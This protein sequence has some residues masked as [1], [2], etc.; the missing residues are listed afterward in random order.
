MTS[1]ELKSLVSGSFTLNQNEYLKYQFPDPV[2][3]SD[4]TLMQKPV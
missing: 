1:K 2:V 4:G 3:L